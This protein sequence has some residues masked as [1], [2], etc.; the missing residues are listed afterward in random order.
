MSSQPAMK[1][2]ATREPIKSIPRIT[3]MALLFSCI[4]SL[5][6]V[7]SLPHAGHMIAC[8]VPPSIK[9]FICLIPCLSEPM[10]LHACLLGCICHTFHLYGGMRDELTRGRTAGASS[11]GWQG[12]GALRTCASKAR[13]KLK[14]LGSLSCAMTM[15][16]S[17]AF[18]VLVQ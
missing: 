6:K 8:T 14:Y 10:C 3:A 13:Q 11:A 15:T 16:P 9:H 2:R 17:T 4:V 7:K 1:I 5:P 18:I 12:A